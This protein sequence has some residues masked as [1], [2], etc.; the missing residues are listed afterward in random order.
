M[1]C[2]PGRLPDLDAAGAL[3]RAADLARD[4]VYVMIGFSVLTFQ[5]AQVRRR[6]LEKAIG[7]RVRLPRP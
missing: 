5:R 1:T 4:A 7:E 6:E 3:D 2:S